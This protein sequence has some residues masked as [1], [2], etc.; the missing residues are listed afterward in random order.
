MEKEVF[1]LRLERLDSGYTIS[2]CCHEDKIFSGRGVYDEI[3]TAYKSEA[4]TGVAEALTRFKELD[5]AHKKEE[6]S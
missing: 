1:N 2:Y 4:F 5:K 6:K 3:P